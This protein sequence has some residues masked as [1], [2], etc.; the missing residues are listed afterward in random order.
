LIEVVGRLTLTLNLG[1]SFEGNQ[2]TDLFER[3]AER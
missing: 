1:V 3:F 2:P